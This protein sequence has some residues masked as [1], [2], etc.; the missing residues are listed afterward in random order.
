MS[1]NRVRSLGFAAALLGLVLGPALPA[2]AQSTG[3]VTG[4]VVDVA[5]QQPLVGAQVMIDGTG[6]GALANDEGTYLI[7]N[8]PA[9]AQTVRAQM[10]GYSSAEANVTVEAGQT[11]TAN[12]TLSQSAISLD[13]IVVTGT[14]GTGQAKRTLGNSVAT[15]SASDITEKMP[16]TDA[17]QLLQGRA[18]GVT[19]MQ[20]TGVVGGGSRMRI[21]GSGSL[22]AGN[23][24]VVFVDGVRVQSGQVQTI[25]GSNTAQPINLLDAFNPNDIESIEVIKGPA[26]ATL[27]GAE[28]ASGVIQIVTKKGRKA[29]GLQWTA[30]FEYGE[31]EWATDQITNYWL[32]TDARM[33][34]LGT[35]PGCGVFTGD[36]PL[37][38]RLLIDQP[39]NP[40]ARSAGVRH[41]YQQNGWTED[42]PCLFPQ[43][44]GCQ[45]NPLRTGVAQ[46]M[47]VA[48][49]GGGDSYNFY[50]SGEKSDQE[51][52]FYNNYS[53]RMGARANFGFVPSEKANFNVNVGYVRQDQ[54]LPLSDNSSN[55]ILRNSYRG[56]AGGLSGAYLPG[57]KSYHPEFSNH[58]N[59]H[60]EQER[61]TVGVTAQYT[62]WDWWQN[63]VTVGM[64]RRQMQN[65]NQND[66]DQTGGI[67]Y[68]GNSALGHAGIDTD[69]VWLWTA[70]VG[71]TLSFDV[72]DDWT[73][74]SSVGMQLTKRTFESFD[75]D[76]WG[77]VANSLN[78]IGDASIRDASQGFSEQTSLGFYVQEQVGFKN[79]LFLTGAVRV[80][81]NSAFGRDFSLVAYPKASVSWVVSEESFF[82]L[83]W[84]DDLKLRAA[85]GRAGNSPAPFSADRTYQASVAVVGD[86][87]VNMITPD[88]YGNPDLKAETGDEIELGFDAS[89]LS[90]RV[91]LD[92][93]FY[94]KTTKDALLSVE[95][96]PS[97]GWT[98]THLVNIGE[99]NNKGIEL[100][101]NATPVVRENV[102]WDLIASFSTAHNKLISFGTDAQGNPIMHEDRFGPF[103]AT[104]RHREGYPLGGY[105][106]I[107]VQR[108]ANG[109]PILGSNGVALLQQCDSWAPDQRANCEEEFVGSPFPTRL[110]GLTNTL[111][112]FNNLQLYAF[113]D[114]QGGH[115]QWCA[116]CSV[117][118]RSDRN[119]KEINDP[120]LDPSHPDYDSW[121]RYE[122][123]LL[124]SQQTVRYIMPADF[125]KLRELSATYTL[126]SSWVDRVGM[127]RASVTLAGRNLWMWTKYEGT[128]DPEVAFTGTSNFETADY[129]S[130]PMQRRWSVSFNLNF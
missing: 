50:L 73:S 15:V 30:N 127:S 117:R 94:N 7:L 125:M 89:L 2:A 77:F 29:E 118:T 120:R 100:A 105:W 83:P 40:D 64:D 79:R 101:V 114:Y 20:T 48:V 90:G 45:P 28:A 111:E 22:N 82:E 11:V 121:G 66:I 67:L 93:T 18:P 78:L 46:N 57:F 25:P 106:S 119:S 71:S 84:V 38:Q 54:Q 128:A 19:L 74:A 5:T 129:G 98:S 61:F 32:C 1:P 88:D 116:I 95:D 107:D 113:L 39:L 47:N 13:Q 53:N 108:D 17:R 31:T 72:N 27:Y 70:D 59:R 75:I 126:P 26:A 102:R 34:N 14:A 43:Q 4:R 33:A 56:E 9:G 23:E 69:N 92:F 112:L 103:I 60:L 110:L 81:D 6:L 91:G 96:P 104:Q 80:D 109:L 44:E 124:L 99:I 122:R 49:R 115:Y 3:T 35:N 58:Y 10:I 41:Q 63:K 65:F 51:G 8:V 52:T 16:V 76:G 87:A 85:W 68:S 62:P 130:I 42:Y 123:G 21:R 24:P 37:E 97:S 86:Q 55:S 36:E 12:L